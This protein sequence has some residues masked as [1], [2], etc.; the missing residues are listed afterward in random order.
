MATARRSRKVF[1]KV[2]FSIGLLYLF[3]PQTAEAFLCIQGAT[4][5]PVVFAS[6]S[7]VDFGTT[8][9]GTTVTR[10]VRVTY[11]CLCTCSGPAN[12][13]VTIDS[14]SPAFSASPSTFTL[15]KS[16]DIFYPESVLVTLS[17]HPTTSTGEGTYNGTMT[18]NPSGSGVVGEPINVTGSGTRPPIP[19]I[20]LGTDTLDFGTA[21]VNTTTARTFIIS[22][23]GNVA[24]TGTMAAS[25]VGGGSIFSVSPSS[26]S[27]PA[28]GSQ[29]VTVSFRPAA[30]L[31]Y[32]GQVSIS[33]N[34]P[35]SA[36]LSVSLVGIGYQP[37][38]NI[39]L[40]PTS[41]EFGNVSVGSQ[42]SRT[43]QISNVGDAVLTGT[44]STSAPFSVSTASFSIGSGGTQSVTVFFN[45]AAA[46]NNSDHL[47]ISSN[48]P[49]APQVVLS[50]T[51]N[52]ASASLV[53]N[54]SSG[55]SGSVSADSINFANALVNPITSEAGYVDIDVSVANTGLEALVISQITSDSPVF[56]PL[57]ASLSVPPGGEG[58]FG[59][60]F[61]PS[62]V[63]DYEGAL[64]LTTND[65]Q[66]PT[67]SFVVA[68]AGVS[69]L[70]LSVS[71]IEVTQAIQTEDNSLPLVAGKPTAI[72][73]FLLPIVTQT[74]GGVTRT[75]PGIIRNADGLLRV[76]KNGV[77]VPGSPFR[78]QNGPITAV[79]D[80]DR[81]LANQ[82][83]N[84]VIPA[85]ATACA[86]CTDK[87]D[88]VLTVEVNPASGTRVSR[89]LENDYSN[90]LYAWSFSFWRNYEPVIYY[91]PISLTIGSKSY[92]MRSLSEMSGGSSFFSKLFP[93]SGFQYVRRPPISYNR[94]LTDWTVWELFR[95]LF[96]ASHLGTST[97]PDRTYGWWPSGY[98]YYVSGSAYATGYAPPGP[99][100]VA[101][102]GGLRLPE[103][104]E[105]FAHE[106][107][108]TYGLCH[109]HEDCPSIILNGAPYSDGH[110][111]EQTGIEEVGFDV[112]EG[113]AILPLP[114]ECYTNP[115]STS[116]GISGAIDFMAYKTNST[117][118]SMWIH[119]QR[120]Q[121]LF[122]RL[123]TRLA[124]PATA[125]GFTDNGVAPEPVL[126]I[127]GFIDDQGGGKIDPV[128]ATDS[129]PDAIE[130]DETSTYL[131][132]FLDEAGNPVFEYPLSLPPGGDFSGGEVDNLIPF[133]LIVPDLDEAARILL[134]SRADGRVL[135]ERR[136]TN[137]PPVVAWQ[138]PSGG[139]RFQGTIDAAWNGTDADGDPLTYSVLYSRDGGASFDA[140]AAD[141]ERASLSYDA[142]Q[143]GGSENARL[144]I[145]ATDGF[146]TT[147]AD[148]PS[149]KVTSKP[150][151]L[152]IVSP[153]DGETYL[154]GASVPLEADVHDPEDGSVAVEWRSS[155]DGDLDPANPAPLSL[156]THTLTATA[157]DFDENTVSR[158]V[159]ITIVSGAF[160]PRADAGP[161]QFVDEEETLALDASASF[162]PNE[163]DALTYDWLQTGGPAVTLDDPAGSRPVFTV[164]RVDQ[165]VVL[166]FRLTATDPDGN[167]G[168]DSVNV[169]VRNVYYPLLRLPN[170]ELDFGEVAL[171]ENASQTMRVSNEGNEDLL[172]N[173]FETSRPVFTVS[174][175]SLT[176]PPGGSSEVH[177]AF[178]PDRAA[179]FEGS[180]WV[181]SNSVV[182]V[183]S[184]VVLKGSSP[185]PAVEINDNLAGGDLPPVPQVPETSPDE[186]PEPPSAGSSHDENAGADNGPGYQFTGVGGCHLVQP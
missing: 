33:S 143:L 138:S 24:L 21:T 112:M 169:V 3:S 123:R 16:G 62:L 164:P 170:G 161:D 160:A 77:A 159:T 158:S 111:H 44:L 163:E 34:D 18:I 165:D 144:R 137:H 175:S 95:R 6:P 181:Q 81:S 5:T 94:D 106:I 124:D 127:S 17:F 135:A 186:E 42:S 88:L 98:A 26:F 102:G 27:V 155:L 73:A 173:A 51:G 52:G 133:S 184:T 9:L 41:L 75:G 79:P 85:S 182:G 12:T 31:I 168:T 121:F 70:D 39:D 43:L 171:G 1:S 40:N 180:L 122:D 4:Y 183:S 65:Y 148:S 53:V 82:T 14:P 174:P 116:C 131:V 157:A 96:V 149:F 60:R 61:Q 76:T 145:V 178:A 91:I 22:N 67:W 147:T 20:G 11:S 38:P 80:A 30:A 179:S 167:I 185:E 156:G 154:D 101:M 97:P 54:A 35:D 86:D 23:A 84:F 55:A 119:P 25:T 107:G 48:D 118:Q 132:R 49:D 125:R 120:Y 99:S 68:G 36:S 45:P 63:G 151:I 114:Y 58:T 87:N 93:I 142:S 136:K 150:P 71:R 64:A 128:Y 110:R 105:T 109:T 152:S 89:I 103:P 172:I 7:S 117:R 28:G 162:D 37:Q 19:D 47:T 129:I 134:V 13:V 2:L 115:S 8:N 177:V 139:E 90:N 57:D 46:A 32:S 29:N 74:G 108:H 146:N 59:V 83:L 113:K 72:R 104:E 100:R 66:H 15:P 10:T 141:I 126:M 50:L 140:I 69:N 92:P 130:E 56:Q 176:I 166:E 153:R 78:S